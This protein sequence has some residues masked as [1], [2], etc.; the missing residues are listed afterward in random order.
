MSVYCVFRLRC[1]VV[2]THSNRS[3]EWTC[4][5][6]VSSDCDI[7]FSRTSDASLTVTIVQDHLGLRVRVLVQVMQSSGVERRRSSDDSVNFVSLGQE[8]LGEVGS[9]SMASSRR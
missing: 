2:K 4:I 5:T 3:L 9:V 7:N 1:N 6:R 8:Q